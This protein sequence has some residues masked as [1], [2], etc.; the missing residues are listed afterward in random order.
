VIIFFDFYPKQHFNYF[1]RFKFLRILINPTY[2][3]Y[4]EISEAFHKVLLDLKAKGY[5]KK[6]LDGWRN[7]C[8]H[9][10]SRF[11]QKP[12]FKIE[13]ASVS[14]FGIKSYGCHVNGYIKKDGQYYLWIARR[15]YQKPTYPGMLDNFVTN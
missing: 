13:R 12:L 15:S 8:Y 9:V 2:K 10:R 4:D 7:E 11:S 5:F 6:E 1:S 3:T 14:L